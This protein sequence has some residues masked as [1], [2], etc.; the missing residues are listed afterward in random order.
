[1]SVDQSAMHA[2]TAFRAPEAYPEW[3]SRGNEVCKKWYSRLQ[4]PRYDDGARHERD[5]CCLANTLAINVNNH[6]RRLKKA[7]MF[8]SLMLIQSWAEPEYPGFLLTIAQIIC[9]SRHIQKFN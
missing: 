5:W 8:T 7:S 9:F 4:R 1:M 6:L 2:P 3:P